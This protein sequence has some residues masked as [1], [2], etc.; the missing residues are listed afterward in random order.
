[1]IGNIFP[2]MELI[3]RKNNDTK[4]NDTNVWRVH[5][6]PGDAPARVKTPPGPPRPDNASEQ[7]QHFF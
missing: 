6:P 2:N 7:K 3:W 1:M 4:R 5:N